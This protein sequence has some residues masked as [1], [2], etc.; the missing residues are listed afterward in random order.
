ME[1]IQF[2]IEGISPLKMDKFVEGQQPKN[3]DG[4]MKQA[5]E[6]AYRD[7]KGNLAVPSGAL[8]AAM[9]LAASQVGR[10]MEA[11]KHRQD[12]AAMVFVEGDNLSLKKKDYDCIAKDIVTRK[13]Q[14]DK[15]TRVTTYRPLIKE[16][17]VSGY[18]N[19]F[20]IPKEFLKECLELAGIRFGLLSHRPEFG[21]FKVN[22]FQVV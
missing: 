1:K 9:R 3:D 22:K 10:K 17:K 15:V 13:G 2:E 4:W 7:E 21:R 6:K 20:G 18:I 5:S 11:K 12:I 8:K 19:N 14:G 16:W